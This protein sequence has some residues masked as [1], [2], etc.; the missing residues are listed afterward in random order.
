M[1]T[2]TRGWNETESAH[3]GRVLDENVLR[4]LRTRDP[5]FL[6]R[7]FRE[8]NPY[9][10]RIG[11]ANGLGHD[12]VLE[13]LHQT[14]HTFFETIERF[15]GRSQVR[16][17]V[18]GILFNKIREHR[19]LIS[20]HVPEEDPN[21]IM[22]R[23]FTAE[24]WWRAEPPDPQRLFESKQI[25]GF[26]SECMHGLSDRQ[27][28]VFVM[29]EVEEESAQT[30]CDTLGLTIS[31]ARVLLFRAKEKLRKCLEGKLGEEGRT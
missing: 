2:R 28:A 13:L 20:R 26:I 10:S 8:I 17:F 7:T 18:C 31:H 19:R 30:V 27:T 29:T 4:L 9:L 22:D 14:W 15:E 21:R 5:E 24:G 6:E 12:D 23:A 1:T 16:T 25:T 11:L 3:G